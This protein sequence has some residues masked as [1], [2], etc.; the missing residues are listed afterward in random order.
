MR[1]R[2]AALTASL[3]LVVLASA[4]PTGWAETVRLPDTG[5]GAQA[6]V[7]A[8]VL[9]APDATLQIPAIALRKSVYTGGQATIDRGVITH[10]VGPGLPTAR[11]GGV[12]LYWVAGHNG[13]HGSPFAALPRLSVGAS[14]TVTNRAGT[15]FRYRIVRRVV[16]GTR[17]PAS[18][19]AGSGARI[20]LQTCV[21]T[22]QRLLVFGQRV[23]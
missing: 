1:T 6:V 7:G 13:S 9:P 20:M 17:I 18:L 8:S 11:P 16:V 10:F 14:V 3:L 12:G 21:G 15:S 23:S 22:T 5:A 2:R 4:M 19:L